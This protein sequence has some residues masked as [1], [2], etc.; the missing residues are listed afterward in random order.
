MRSFPNQVLKNEN[1][2]RPGAYMTAFESQWTFHALRYLGMPADAHATTNFP[3]DQV[4]DRRAEKTITKFQS[5]APGSIRFR[6]EN[7][8]RVGSDFLRLIEPASQSR[9]L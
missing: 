9:N 8:S 5:A 4:Q 1:R 3:H 7:R 6:G 2:L